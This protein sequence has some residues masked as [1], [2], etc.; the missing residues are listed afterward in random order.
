[1]AFNSM[2]YLKQG[3]VDFVFSLTTYDCNYI[4]Q[5][6]RENEDKNAIIKG[7]LP[8]L[9]NEYSRFCFDI[10]Y[11]NDEFAKETKYLLDKGFKITDDKI[12]NILNN[13]SWGKDY[14][15]EHRNEIVDELKEETIIELFKIIFSHFKEYQDY[16]GY[17]KI[18]KNLHIRYLFMKYLIENE[19]SKLPFIYDNFFNYLTS[20]T[21]QKFEQLTFLPVLMDVSDISALAYS[22]LKSSL[23]RQYFDDLKEFILTNYESNDLAKQFL[24]LKE[25]KVT[26]NSWKCYQDDEGVAEFSRDATRLFETSATYKLY[27]LENYSSLIKDEIL[28]SFAKKINIFRKEDRDTLSKIFY[29]NLG[30]YIL[31]Y[32][33]KYLSLSKEETCEYIGTGSTS[34]VYRIG[35]FVLK[36]VEMKWS[37]EDVICPNLYVF[38]KNL[39][40]I[41]IRNDRGYVQAGLEVEQYLKKDARDVPDE[42][43]ANIRKELKRLGFFYNDTLMYGC[44]G[45]NCRMLDSYLDADCP[46]PRSLPDWFKE[47]PVV[48]VDRD[49]IYKNEKSL[50]GRIYIKQ[51]QERWD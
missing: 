7:F 24:E 42:I 27:I 32:I 39:E 29:H 23:N 10:I 35:D 22:I 49:T 43:F 38:I 8:H 17:F 26:S 5:Y 6:V 46:N 40:E 11:D 41:Y 45:D 34:T 31:E 18:H 21:H 9:L 20:Y 16:I 48:I 1:M 25:E 47:Y 2:D 19:P 4:I 12:I 3:K 50:S 36:L 30:K 13:T 37:Y 14:I 51:I 33:D 28:N 15:F 44:C